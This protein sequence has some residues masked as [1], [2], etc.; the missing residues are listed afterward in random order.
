[1]VIGDLG[2]DTE[3]DQETKKRILIIDDERIIID[4]LKYFFED[5]G[6][7]VAVDIDAR[8][9]VESARSFKPDIILLDLRLPKV[10]GIEACQMLSKDPQTNGIPIIIVS[11]LVKMADIREAYK[12]GVVGYFTKPYDLQQLYGEVE[13]A[14]VYKR[15]EIR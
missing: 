11:A 6:Y 7:E 10:G 12:A 8:N 14:I 3:M 9:I 1:L 5:K 4:S 15:G 2:I 13:K